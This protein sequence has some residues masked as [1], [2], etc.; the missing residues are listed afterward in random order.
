ML[1]ELHIRNY[2]LIDRLT[3]SFGPGL[4]V[5]T[6]ET[7]AGKSIIVDCLLLLLGDR[8]SQEAI[9][10]GEELS[11]VEGAFSVESPSLLAWCEEMGFAAENGMVILSREIHRS[12]KHRCRVNGRIVTLGTLA[13]IGVRL[14][15]LHGQHDNQSLMRPGSQ[16]ALLDAFGGEKVES[17]RQEVEGL[18]RRWRR[19]KQERA[20]LMSEERARVQRQDLLRFQLEEI[21][22]A[23]VQPDEE[24]ILEIERRRLASAERLARDIG[25]AYGTLYDGEEGAPSAIDSLSRALTAVQTC[26]L[27]D[28]SLSNVAKLLDDAAVQATEAAHEM[29]GYRDNIE[30]DPERLAQLESRADLLQRLKR[31]YGATLAEVIAYRDQIAAELSSLESREERLAELGVEI[32]RTERELTELSARLSSIRAEVAQKLSSAIEAE[33]EELNMSKTRFQVVL[34]QT[35]DPDGIP[36]QDLSDQRIAV[37]AHGVDDVAFLI[38]ANVGEEPKPLT[39][40]AS[41]GELS[42]I[43]LALKSILARLDE[44]PTLI[45]DEVDTGVGGRAAQ[46]VANKLSRLADMRQVLCV[47]HLPQIA[48]HADMHLVV[49]K[50]QEGDRTVTSVKQL[51]MN[52]RVLELARMLGGATLTE[53]TLLHAGEMLELARQAK[54]AG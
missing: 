29:R 12:G 47:T 45:F 3:L 50:R 26:A 41:G 23:D 20:T 21:T 16:L 53:T 25:Q 33:L 51:N 1:T 10:S 48:S 28:P 30:A 13:E 19:A 32:D 22:K 49:E 15:D 43:M 31:K 6:G 24:Q 37:A 52:E 35:P 40:V 9:R 18:W 42:R 39:K 8:A 54:R 46:A 17:L 4:T 36:A 44:I 11:V 27:L 2:A 7:G 14:M 38:S 5:L 34:G